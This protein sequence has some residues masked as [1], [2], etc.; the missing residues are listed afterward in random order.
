MVEAPPN[1]R[2]HQFLMFM[3]VTLSAGLAARRGLR[4][5]GSSIPSSLDIRPTFRA[6]RIVVLISEA[7][8][9]LDL[10]GKSLTKI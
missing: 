8:M 2:R 6:V 7:D 3:T 5:G 10:R 9:P 4:F 1:F